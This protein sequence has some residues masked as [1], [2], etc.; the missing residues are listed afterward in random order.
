MRRVVDGPSRTVVFPFAVATARAV[1]AVSAAAVVLA[2]CGNTRTA[3]PRATVPV[4]TGGFQTLT[5]AADGVAL[6]APRGWSVTPG[7]APLV[8]TITSG[9][10]VVTL[11]RFPRTAAPPSGAPALQAAERTLLVEART[12]DPRLRVIGAS[13]TTVAGA[14]AVVLNVVEHVNGHMRR[15][16]SIHVFVP[17]AE[18]VLDAFAPA[19]MFRSADRS[20]FEPMARSLSPAPAA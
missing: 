18:L 4:A 9:P 3:V 1:V 2:G 14:P 12:R 7:A 10:A 17:H 15:T 8:S 20:V 13:T 11:W 6:R 16:R 19:R 5:Y